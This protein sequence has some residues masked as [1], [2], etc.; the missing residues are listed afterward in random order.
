MASSSESKRWT[1]SAA[2]ATTVAARRALAILTAVLGIALAL[3]ASLAAGLATQRAQTALPIAVALTMGVVWLVTR[4]WSAPPRA[5]RTTAVDVP[6]RGVIAV[7][8]VERG[9][10]SC[11]YDAAR[12]ILWARGWLGIPQ[13]CVQAAPETACEIVDALARRERGLRTLGALP[14]IFTIPLIGSLVAL[15]IGCALSFGVV[16]LIAGPPHI[17]LP[18]AAVTIPLAILAFRPARVELSDASLRWRWWWLT[19]ELPL[20]SIERVA[21]TTET[22]RVHMVDGAVHRLRVRMSSGGS[23]IGVVFE[24]RG[25]DQLAA[26]ARFVESRSRRALAVAFE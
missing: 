8:G 10:R 6:R 22:L 18:A 20:S 21:A 7:G 15:A 11:V 19:R 13:A 2:P 1:V 16:M 12:E 5:M 26:F 14:G 17:G 23:L 3:G 24:D 4:L 25:R 9:V